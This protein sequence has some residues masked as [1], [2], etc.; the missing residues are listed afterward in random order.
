MR[1]LIDELL[2]IARQEDLDLEEISL[3][4]AAT[5]AWQTVSTEEMEL[6]IE[7]TGT[8]RADAN[9]LRRLFENLYWNALSHGEASTIR[10]GLLET[11]GFYVAD[12]GS[13]IPPS[14]RE[15]VFETGFST[16]EEGTGYGLAIVQ[17]ICD[18][19]DWEITLV[20]SE[21]GGARF[22]LTTGDVCC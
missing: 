7:E 13:G 4:Q 12:D 1:N 19:H 9:H 3:Q 10:I 22:E 14:K 20:D 17:G 5:E 6:V 18:T 11:D 15:Q 8:V 16:D 2:R 21:D